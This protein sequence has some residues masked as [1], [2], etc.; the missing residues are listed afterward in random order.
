M[1]TGSVAHRQERDP[2]GLG[3]R[4]SGQR[5]AEFGC[6]LHRTR[7]IAQAGVD[8]AAVDMQQPPCGRHER[9]RRRAAG[10]LSQAAAFRGQLLGPWPVPGP[11][12][13]LGEGP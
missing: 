7:R 11:A 6:E 9:D 4:G 12:L 13:V 10:I 3:R 1:G 5:H 2:E 8:P